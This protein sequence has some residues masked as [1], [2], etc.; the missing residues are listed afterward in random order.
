MHWGT[1]R[2]PS[3]RPAS[4]TGSI[5]LRVSQGQRRMLIYTSSQPNLLCGAV[6]PAASNLSSGITGY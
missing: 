4:E 6:T 2:E 5:D 3:V 1:G